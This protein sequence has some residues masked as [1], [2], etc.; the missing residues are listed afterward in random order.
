[1]ERI[2]NWIKEHPFI[3]GGVVLVVIG[4]WYLY[5]VYSSGSSASGTTVVAGAAAGPSD[6]SYAAQASQSQTSAAQEVADTQT[7][8]SL[9][10]ALGQQATQQQ[11]NTLAAGVANQSTVSQAATA[12][13]ASYAGLTA[14][15]AGYA[16]AVEETITGANRD[17]SIAGFNLAGLQD[18]NATNL[19]G[20][21]DTNASNVT[22]AGI[23]SYTAL[24]TAA[25][26][27]AAVQDTN[28][29]AQNINGQN[30][31]GAID[32]AGIQSQT[33]LGVSADQL[34]AIKDQDFTAYA[35]DHD[36][37][38][39]QQL[40]ITTQG[41]VD[42]NLI[43]TQGLIAGEGIAAEYGLGIGQQALQSHGLDEVA[44][45]VF[46][47]GGE[48]GVEQVAAFL[49]ALGAPGAAS[50]GQAGASVGV[51]QN[52]GG[53]TPG[54]IISALGNVVGVGLL[55]SFGLPSFSTPSLPSVTSTFSPS[56]PASS[57][58]T[59]GTV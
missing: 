13:Y 45:G 10:V 25:D 15:E 3:T 7:A 54:G 34:S 20:L 39:T 36:Q 44:S 40:G 2:W 29:T 55:G 16:A 5:E 48:G 17:V 37:Q 51:A 57:P 31:Q 8:A 22:I 53:N 4:L 23:Q 6:A 28:Q 19:A 58:A 43:N 32:I 59:S 30:V 9:A 41:Q 18:T 46:N 12:Q 42:N 47:K 26:Q 52:S 38:A 1:M 21:K 14:A 11:A 56:L 27:L 35:I 33:T 50:V 49:G 24:G